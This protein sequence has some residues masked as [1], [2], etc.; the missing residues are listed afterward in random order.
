MAKARPTCELNSSQK[1]KNYFKHLHTVVDTNH[2]SKSYPISNT[3]SNL[4]PRATGVKVFMLADKYSAIVKFI[5]YD[6]KNSYGD[7]DK[8][9][10]LKCPFFRHLHLEKEKLC[11]TEIT[12]YSLLSALHWSTGT[13][14][15]VTCQTNRMGDVFT[16]F[17]HQPV[18]ENW[19][20]CEFH[21]NNCRVNFISNFIS[22]TSFHKMYK[23]P[24]QVFPD[25]AFDKTNPW[26]KMVKPGFCG[27]K[28]A[29]KAGEELMPSMVW[30]YRSH[31]HN[32]DVVDQLCLSLLLLIAPGMVFNITIPN[33]QPRVIGLLSSLVLMKHG[34]SI[35]LYT[36]APFL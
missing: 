25:T 9:K 3:T 30:E 2:H 24:S 13:R 18:E 6:G 22:A 26:V 14:F 23:H 31:Y 35:L 36:N 17:V 15:V 21:F 27:N 29:F 32:V 10:T 5:V 1:S 8:N 16:N 20:K 4:K 28:K 19:R 11:S 7:L 12:V 33:G 34:P